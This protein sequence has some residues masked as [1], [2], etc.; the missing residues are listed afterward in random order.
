M[1]Q[2]NYLLELTFSTNPHKLQNLSFNLAVMFLS[3]PKDFEDISKT[4]ASRALATPCKTGDEMFMHKHII[5]I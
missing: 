3:A 5:L 2:S 1:P 4:N